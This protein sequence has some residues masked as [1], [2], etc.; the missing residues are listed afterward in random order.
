VTW[1]PYSKYNN[2]WR[3]IPI[4]LCRLSCGH[5]EIKSHISE[6][7]DAIKSPFPSDRIFLS[8][9]NATKRNEIPRPNPNAPIIDITMKNG[10]CVSVGISISYDEDHIICPSINAGTVKTNV[11]IRIINQHFTT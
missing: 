5:H 6:R 2:F 11:T 9:G 7:Y 8:N 10:T 4:C 1:K 3:S